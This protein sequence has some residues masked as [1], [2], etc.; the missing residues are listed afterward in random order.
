MMRRLFYRAKN[1]IYFDYEAFIDMAKESGVVDF[2]LLVPISY[3]NDT[4]KMGATL[5]PIGNR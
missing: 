2:E 5:I 3:S 1:D 4:R